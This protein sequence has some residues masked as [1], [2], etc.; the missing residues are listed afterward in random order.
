[1]SK[2][3]VI[4]I[5]IDGAAVGL[6]K[7]WMEEGILPNFKTAKESGVMGN[8]KTVIPPMTATGWVSLSTGKNPGKHGVFDF[9]KISNYEKKV[10]SSRDIKAKHIWQILSERNKKVI[11]VNPPVSFPPDQ[12]NGY[13]VG[14]MLTPS[15]TSEYTYPSSLKDELAKMGYLIGV[16]LD[17]GLRSNYAR[18][19]VMNKNEKSR[20]KLIDVFNNIDEKRVE[21]IEELSGRIDWDYIYVMFEG[22]D[23]LQHYYWNDAD[24]YVIR[25]HYRKVDELLGRFM[26]MLDKDTIIIVGS[27]H[28]FSG[29]KYKFYVNNFLSGLGLLKGREEAKGRG[30]ILRTGKDMLSFAAKIGVPVQRLLERK[31][32]FRFYK[33]L[34][35]PFIDWERT[36]AYMINETSRGIWINLEARQEKG[37]VKKSEYRALRQSI[38][39]ALNSLKNPKTG[40]KIVRAYA[41]EDVY[42]G[43]HTHDA[44]DILIVTEENYSVEPIMHERPGEIAKN[45]F[46][47]ETTI[48]ER[49]ADHAMEGLFMMLGGGVKKNI[50]GDVSIV[51]ITPTVLTIL[52][53]DIPKDIDGKVLSQYIG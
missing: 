6:I 44:P 26:K 37:I 3:R 24:F 27:D 34:Y 43:I 20:R 8:L 41:R 15:Y 14:G 12:V 38:I 4:F 25:E 28:G 22:T 52:G 53:V 47:E 39:D 2:K 29:I 5:G 13:F 45:G 50:T 9:Y 18:S 48:G 33:N 32:M 1:M 31:F 11:V 21:L 51:D 30:F 40:E 10:I 49:N 17:P 36:S 7:P 16:E 35:K 42:S 19:F 46:I 23:R